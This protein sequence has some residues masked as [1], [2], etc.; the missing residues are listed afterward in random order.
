[1]PDSNS[2]LGPDAAI[3]QPKIDHQKALNDLKQSQSK[4]RELS[5]PERQRLLDE[6]VQNQKERDE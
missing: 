4:P 5:S 2:K 1:M 6:M 3:F